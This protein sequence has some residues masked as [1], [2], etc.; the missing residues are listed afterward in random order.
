MKSSISSRVDAYS[1]VTDHI[2]A[3]LEQG[4]RPWMKPWTGGEVAGVKLPARHCGTPYRGINI[5]LLWSASMAN[6]FI[7]SKWMTYRQADELGGHVR[8]GEHGTMVV[9]GDSF[10]TTEQDDE[11][12]DIE[13]RIR[14]MRAYTVFNVEQIDDLP[15]RHYD[16]P[17]QPGD[18]AQILKTAKQFFAAT[19]AMFRHGGDQA[20]YAPAPDVI[21]LPFP[22]TFRDVESYAAIKA[23]ELTHWTAH[24]SRL[25]RSFGVSRF[26]NEAY[27]REELVAELGAAFLCATLGI[28]PEVREDHAAYIA[29]WFELLKYDR[30]AIF[31]ASA[32]AQRA[33]DYLH[34]LQEP[35]AAAV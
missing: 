19:Q 22:E 29:S 11:G 30:R 24:S 2:I 25:D 7:A 4:V 13:R 34:S 21:R 32:H 18:R 6:D 33:V 15:S 3:D 27:A 31:Q 1:R 12:E 26:G 28:T 9:Y 5:I 23:H 20:Y 10:K 17:A 16:A 8:E 14:F 35:P